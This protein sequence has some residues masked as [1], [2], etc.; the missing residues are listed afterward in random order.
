MVIDYKIVQ[1]RRVE[2]RMRMEVSYEHDYEYE[3]SVSKFAGWAC[4]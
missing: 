4:A 2:N 1:Q 3:D